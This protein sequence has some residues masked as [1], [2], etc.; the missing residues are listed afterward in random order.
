MAKMRAFL[1][2]LSCKNQL[3][4]Q[5]MRF[6]ESKIWSIQKKALLLHPLS[7]NGQSYDLPF[8]RFS[9]VYIAE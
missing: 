1:P 2:Y 9:E 4:L 7:K 3:F 8:Q 6:F 5:K